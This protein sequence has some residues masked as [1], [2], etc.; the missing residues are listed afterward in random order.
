M[1]DR[2]DHKIAGPSVFGSKQAWKLW[3]TSWMTSREV[4]ASLSLS[5]ILGHI[6]LAIYLEM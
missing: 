2:M 6:L 3:A 4:V 5:H 1:G